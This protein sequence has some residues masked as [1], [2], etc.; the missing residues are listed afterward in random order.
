MATIG[1][2]QYDTLPSRKVAFLGL[3]V[4]GLPMAG[5]LARAGHTVRVY[6]RSG[7]KANAYVTEFG[8]TSAATP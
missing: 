6:N 2:R 8:G 7:S 3:S 1:Q 4:M 5:H